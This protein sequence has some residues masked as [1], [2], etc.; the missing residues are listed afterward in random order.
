MK[1]ISTFLASLAIAAIPAASFAAT[2]TGTLNATATV[3]AK[4]VVASTSNVVFGAIDPTVN[5]NYDGSGSITTRC[6]KN[7]PSFL[8]V[9]PTVAGPLRMASG[10]TG[11]NIT[12]GLYSDSGRS[13]AFP[14]ATGGAK[15]AHPG[16]QTATLYGRVVVASGQND[17]VAAASDYTQALTATIEY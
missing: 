15:T 4:C 13:T 8:F 6:T 10:T 3:T 5:A 11:D 7:T 1:R 17:T 12:Y 16:N 2:A 14:S 9:A